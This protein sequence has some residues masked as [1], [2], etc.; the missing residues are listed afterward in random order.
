L[1]KGLSSGRYMAAAEPF[2]RNIAASFAG[3]AVFL[4]DA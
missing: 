3:A 4:G 1:L 2:K